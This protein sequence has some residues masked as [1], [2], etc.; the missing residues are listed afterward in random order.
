MQIAAHSIA[1]GAILV[2]GDTAFRHVMGL[3]GLENLA[4]DS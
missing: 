4:A 2:S 1:V 3:V